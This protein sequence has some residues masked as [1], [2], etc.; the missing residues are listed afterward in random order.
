MLEEAGQSSSCG[1]PGLQQSNP[2]R[3]AHHGPFL[4]KQE[5]SLSKNMAIYCSICFLLLNSTVMNV[6]YLFIYF[7]LSSKFRRCVSI[8]T[9][10]CSG[11]PNNL[12]HIWVWENGFH[13][14]EDSVSPHIQWASGSGTGCLMW[15]SFTVDHHGPFLLYLQCQEVF[16]SSVEKGE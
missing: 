8:S 13:S 1:Q 12:D 7:K 5:Q 4:I 9:V 16:S 14:L 6:L 11:Q 10:C 15:Q 3:R 2:M